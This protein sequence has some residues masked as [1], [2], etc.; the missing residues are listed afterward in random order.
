MSLIATVYAVLMAY[1]RFARNVF[2]LVV[3]F[4]LSTGLLFIGCKTDDGDFIDDHKLNTKLI[5]TWTSTYGD[6]YNITSTK[7]TYDDGYGGG[8]AG[9]IKYVSNFSDVAG[10]IIIEYDEDH[11]PSYW[12]YD[13]NWQPVKELP[14]KGDFI[15]IYYK[16]LKSGVSVSMAGAYIDGG[17]EEKTLDAAIKAFTMGNEGKYIATYG[18]Y[19]K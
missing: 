7:L 13:E 4:C 18:I 2:A 3:L 5:E 12:E 11:K 9:T 14:L 19:S 15:G 8:S 10:V 6:S 17:A 1:T 16:D